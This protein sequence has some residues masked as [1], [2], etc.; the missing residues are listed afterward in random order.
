VLILGSL[1]GVASL[2]AQQY[3][4]HPRN[5]FWDLMGELFG[6]GRELAYAQ[7]CER[8][9]AAGV[10]VWDVLHAARRPGSLDADIDLRSLIANDFTALFASQPQLRTVAFNGQ[11]AATLFRRNVLPA[12]APLPTLRLLTLPSTSPAH[13]GRTRAQKLTLWRQLLGAQLQLSRPD[14]VR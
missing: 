12:L 9:T 6:A 5:L 3:Y 13:A 7:R 10:A 11:T 4:A 2:E 8:L 14:S 1:P